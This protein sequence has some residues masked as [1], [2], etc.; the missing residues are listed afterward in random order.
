M[1]TPGARRIRQRARALSS[2]NGHRPALWARPTLWPVVLRAGVTTIAWL[3]AIAAVVIAA[4]VL[5]G[6]G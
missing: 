5:L 6:G 3:V 2:R 4:V 1:S